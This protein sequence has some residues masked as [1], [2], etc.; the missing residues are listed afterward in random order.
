MVIDLPKCNSDTDETDPIELEVFPNPFNK[1]SNS[2]LSIRYKQ[3]A[4]STVKIYLSGLDVYG[5]YKSP[6]EVVDF[7]SQTIVNNITTKRIHANSLM[8]GM[9]YL[10]VIV[11]GEVQVR[12][13]KVQ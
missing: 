6:Q 5:N 13:I 1:S 2:E 3:P 7:N 4:N 11:S 8:I 9:N 10:Q 12:S